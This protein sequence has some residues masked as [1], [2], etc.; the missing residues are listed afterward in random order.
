MF[1]AAGVERRISIKSA[2]H[3]EIIHTNAGVLGFLTA[4][5][6]ADFYPNGGQKQ[7]GCITGTCSHLRSYEYFAES[8]VSDKGFF[9]KKCKNYQEA[10]DGV[11]AGDEGFMGGSKDHLPYVGSFHLTTNS[12]NPFAKGK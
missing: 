4:I 12:E 9:G 5:G 10:I 8:I 11:C 7:L 3:V 1:F 2:H 6:K